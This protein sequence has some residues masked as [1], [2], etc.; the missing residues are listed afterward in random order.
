MLARERWQVR[1]IE[2]LER[3]YDERLRQVAQYGHNEDLADG[4]GP[5]AA[6]L[7]PYSNDPATEVQH[8]FRAEYEGHELVQGL[9]T[10][11]HLVREELAEAFQAGDTDELIEELIQVAAL[12]VSWVEKKLIL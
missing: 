5:E 8:R 3:V 2:V 12:C 9:P 1:T 7:A 11:M 4:T 6:W 10:W